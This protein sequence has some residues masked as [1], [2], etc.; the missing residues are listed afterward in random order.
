MNVSPPPADVWVIVRARNEAGT[1]RE[2]LD[3]LLAV[4]YRVVVVDDGSTDATSALAASR[5]A[6]VVR[7]AV[8]IGPGA[9][10]TTGLVAALERGAA[11]VAT[12]D[13]DGQ[14]DVDDLPRLLAPL[15]AGEADVVFGSRFLRR[16]DRIRVPPARRLLLRGGI[17]FNALFTGRLLSDAHNGLRAFTRRAAAA[18]DLRE[19]GFAYATELLDQVARRKFRLL[20]VP[21]SVSYTRRSLA[22]GQT[23]WN[24]VN[25]VL[26]FLA[27]KVFR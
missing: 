2:V 6:L 19:T 15:A 17:V 3:R 12:L 20:E 24:A 18:L 13:A 1:L 21:V 10:L 27:G 16:E 25:I 23:G 9:A 5:G 7:H 11:Y 14:H 26:D 8:N 22:K 4:G